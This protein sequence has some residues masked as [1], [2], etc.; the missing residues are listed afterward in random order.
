MPTKTLVKSLLILAILLLI[1]TF[2]AGCAAKPKEAL[3]FQEACILNLYVSNSQGLI[4][5]WL[6][7]VDPAGQPISSCP[8][9]EFSG[10]VWGLRNPEGDVS[11][12]NPETLLFNCGEDTLS[13]DTLPFSAGQERSTLVD[14]TGSLQS[15]E[16]A[17]K[18]FQINVYVDGSE[19]SFEYVAPK[20][21]EMN[22]AKLLSI[23][24][25][26]SP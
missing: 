3:C 23:N 5:L 6:D 14:I 2:T 18:V 24:S 16:D 7:M 1:T 26:T 20:E 22:R 13:V 8:P 4:T 10:R 15:R 21:N 17:G 11:V 9:A 19:L 25:L 12:S